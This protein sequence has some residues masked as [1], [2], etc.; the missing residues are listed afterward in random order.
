MGPPLD[1]AGGIDHGRSSAAR[2]MPIQM[3]EKRVIRRGRSALE[4][5]PPPPLIIR[6][7]S[8]P[9]GMIQ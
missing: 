9:R 6:P 1:T 7:V 8:A 5:H 3:A 4:P 2:R